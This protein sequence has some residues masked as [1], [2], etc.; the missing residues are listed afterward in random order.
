MA[1][2]DVLKFKEN[3][4]KS[5][6]KKTKAVVSPLGEFIGDRFGSYENKVN[7]EKTN[8]GAL[9]RELPESE[10]AA[11]KVYEQRYAEQQNKLK[12]DKQSFMEKQRSRAIRRKL[13][14]EQ[15][16]EKK[17]FGGRGLWRGEPV[18]FV[19]EEYSTKQQLEIEQIE[20][21]IYTKIQPYL[22]NKAVTVFDNDNV[23]LVLKDVIEQLNRSATA[24]QD[25]TERQTLL[26]KQ[27][28]VQRDLDYY[29]HKIKERQNLMDFIAEREQRSN[30]AWQGLEKGSTPNNKTVRKQLVELASENAETI[31]SNIPV[32]GRFLGPIANVYGQIKVTMDHITDSG[33][34]I[35]QGTRRRNSFGRIFGAITGAIAGAVIMGGTLAAVGSAVPIIGTAIGGVTG[36]VAGA[37]M[38]FAAGGPLG[39]KAFRALARKNKT[40]RDELDYEMEYTDLKRIRKIYG[41]SEDSVLNMHA[42]MT[43]Q[44]KLFGTGKTKD[45]QKLRK[46]ALE[47]GRDESMVKLLVYFMGQEQMLRKNIHSLG[48]DSI[49]NMSDR[50]RYLAQRQSLVATEDVMEQNQK[51][52]EEKLLPIIKQRGLEL[53]SIEAL[54]IEGNIQPNEVLYIFN[55]VSKL[56]NEGLNGKALEDFVLENHQ[57]MISTMKDDIG[58]VKATDEVLTTLMLK[59]QQITVL[60]QKL[61]QTSEIVQVDYKKSP[62]DSFNEELA[63]IQIDLER[64]QEQAKAIANKRFEMMRERDGIL[65]I[66]QEFREPSEVYSKSKTNFVYQKLQKRNVPGIISKHKDP[67]GDLFEPVVDQKGNTVT[68]IIGKGK[69]AEKVAVLKAKD[70]RSLGEYYLSQEVQERTELARAQFRE[71]LR[72]HGV[73]F[74]KKEIGLFEE[75]FWEIPATDRTLIEIMKRFEGEA[76]TNEKQALE[77]LKVLKENQTILNFIGKVNQ[78][79]GQDIAA[80]N[81]EAKQLINHMAKVSDTLNLPYNIL[82]GQITALQD[83]QTLLEQAS[84]KDVYVRRDLAS[85]HESPIQELFPYTPSGMVQHLMVEGEVVEQN[86]RQVLDRVEQQQVLDDTSFKTAIMAYLNTSEDLS[87]DRFLTVM[88]NYKAQSKEAIATGPLLAVQT[89]LDRIDNLKQSLKK[90]YDPRD[91]YELVDLNRQLMNDLDQVMSSLSENPKTKVETTRAMGPFYQ[92]AGFL[93]RLT[94]SNAE[95]QKMNAAFAIARETELP[96]VKLQE[97]QSS[98]PKSKKPSMM[99]KLLEKAQLAKREKAGPSVEQAPDKQAWQKAD[100]SPEVKSTEPSEDKAKRSSRKRS[101]RRAGG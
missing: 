90:H 38:G 13:R 10:K 12:R 60:E 33:R 97:S 21:D 30:N 98:E 18:A 65:D 71:N 50:R 95:I 73:D 27:E 52:F 84:I 26:K 34:N 85:L 44:I 43:N 6:V 93:S 49:Q 45:L 24:A 29:Q 96:E 61:E 41:L 48:M 88:E 9:Y 28:Q 19:E 53:D 37:V 80:L 20:Y 7:Q 17:R 74:V 76:D 22:R 51:L 66:L 8:K 16:L 23:S 83:I 82:Q 72:E 39:V 87:T 89:T 99:A 101:H 58:G 69:G 57:L 40:L 68:H 35:A 100:V 64:N 15:I 56:A 59:I 79:D 2:S 92:K 1:W 14:H 25:E 86:R 46:E 55:M 54:V 91:A 67:I 62:R 42:Y 11:Q 31:L 75:S 32:V 3:V 47:E 5:D 81:N 63:R 77:Q 94:V 4:D 78:S 36:I 70:V